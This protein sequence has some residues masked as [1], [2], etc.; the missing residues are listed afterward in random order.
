MWLVTGRGG[1]GLPRIDYETSIEEALCFGWVDGQAGTLDDKRSKLYFA[2]RRLGS[3]WS[4]YNKTRVDR[5]LK[6]GL[7][8]E[9]GMAVIE[10]ARA[11][12]SWRIFDSV[13]RLE[14]PVELASALD[15]RPL[16]RANW[17][18]FPDGVKRQ[19]LSSIA[20][21]KRRETRT[22]RIEQAADQA[23]RNERPAR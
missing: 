23:Q 15:A 11:D 2:P 4:R 5:L 19:V 21:A 16:A 8:A 1:S 9:S 10:R 20:L 18:A 6:A 17:D 13:D 7:M 12:G 14:L 22:R 3:P